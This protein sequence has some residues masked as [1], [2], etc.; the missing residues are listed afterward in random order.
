MSLRIFGSA[1]AEFRRFLDS[2]LSRRIE[3][4]GAV[5]RAVARII[6]QVRAGGDRA[7]LDLIRRYDG[8]KLGATRLRVSAAELRAARDALPKAERR[9]LG[10]AA[11]PIPAFHARTGERSFSYRDTLQMRLGQIV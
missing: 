3:S 8:V 7:L 1:S 2:I 11:P 6:G 10:L 9:A 5:D 4:G